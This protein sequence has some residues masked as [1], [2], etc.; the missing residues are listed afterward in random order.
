[1]TRPVSPQSPDAPVRVTLGG[2]VIDPLDAGDAL[3]LIC[4]PSAEREE[5]FVVVTPNISHIAMLERDGDFR[6]SYS[7]ADLVLPDGFPIALAVR[8]FTGREVHRVT[9]A[10]L[11]PRVLERCASLGLSVAL[12]GGGEGSAQAATERARHEHPG[13]D[14]RLAV[15]PRF[16]E[17]PGQADVDRLVDGLP[18]DV[19]V[20]VLGLG[21]PKQELLLEAADRAGRLPRAAFLCFGAAI[22]FYSGRAQRAPESW[23]R[24]NLEWAYRV[25]RE[26]R[27]LAGRYLVA[28]PRFTRVV[29][30]EHRRRTPS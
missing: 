10:D 18:G 8:W 22:D 27:R 12:V 25:R 2:A 6:A 1:M 20:V 28:A 29:L 19:D 14:I 17:R 23:Q 4:R 15:G 16:A 11:L 21:T 5:A 30:R 3:E 24:L 9:G 7:R 13:I 26:P